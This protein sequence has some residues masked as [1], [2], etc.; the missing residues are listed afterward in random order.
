MTKRQRHIE[1]FL[2]VVGLIAVALVVTTSFAVP[3]PSGTLVA[4]STP[5]Q[6]V[7]VVMKENHAFDNYF[8]SFPGADGIPSEASV[9]DGNGGSI[10]PQWLGAASNQ[11]LPP[12]RESIL[13]A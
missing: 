1:T 10:A 13:D 4:G 6:H 11:E 7:F 8:G 2:L 5:I 3:V 12:R 9:P